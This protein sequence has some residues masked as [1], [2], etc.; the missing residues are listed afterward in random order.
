MRTPDHPSGVRRDLRSPNP[1]DPAQLTGDERGQPS[2]SLAERHAR[3]L[4][5]VTPAGELPLVTID[6]RAAATASG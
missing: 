5:G 4:A 6:G 3:T 2:G 1:C